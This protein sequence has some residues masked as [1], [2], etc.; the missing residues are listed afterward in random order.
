MGKDNLYMLHENNFG[1]IV[2]CSCCNQVQVSLGN[3]VFN[4]SKKEYQ[5]FDSYFNEVRESQ[6]QSLNRNQKYII[7]TNKEGVAI[8]VTNDELLATVEL[9]NFA[10]ILLEVSD[11]MTIN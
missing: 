6:I 9:L 10:N 2:N 11:L 4:F 1:Y 7:K 8:T 3:T 5:E